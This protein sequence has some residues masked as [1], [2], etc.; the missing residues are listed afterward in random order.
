MRLLIVLACVI[1]AGCHV[2]KGKRTMKLLQHTGKMKTEVLQHVPIGTGID[3]ARTVMETNGFE[4]SYATY[5]NDGAPYLN[6][7]CR[8]AV[9]WAVSRVWTIQISYDSERVTDVVVSNG[10]VGP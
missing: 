8:E 3:Q 1:V 2:A 4:C 10:L 6:C 7:Q 5:A 9:D